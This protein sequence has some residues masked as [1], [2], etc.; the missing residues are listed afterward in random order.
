MEQAISF[1]EKAVSA[2]RTKLGDQHPDLIA[3]LNNLAITFE[4]NGNLF[5]ALALFEEA[6]GIAS[7][8]L[9]A[10]HPTTLNLKSKRFYLMVDIVAQPVKWMFEDLEK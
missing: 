9:G 10:D 2:T 5:N 8:K 7:S 1:L 6:F 4:T 3:Q